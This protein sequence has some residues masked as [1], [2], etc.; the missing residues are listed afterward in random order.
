MRSAAFVLCLVL[1]A[2]A[3]ESA[4][5]KPLTVKLTARVSGFADMSGT[6]FGGN[7]SSG[8]VITATYTYDT[9]RPDLD[10]RPDVGYYYSYNFSQPQPGEV[11][12]RV[13]AGSLVFESA[14]AP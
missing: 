4:A 12:I 10:S 8:Q 5:A 1:S 11:G 2:V 13:Q 9:A 7:I 6:Q 3:A 14:A